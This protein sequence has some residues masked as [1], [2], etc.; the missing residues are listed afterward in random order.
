MFSEYLSMF[1]FSMAPGKLQK[2][3][4]QKK[5]KT[6]DITNHESTSYT[7]RCELFFPQINFGIYETFKKFYPGV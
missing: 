1:G 4:M 6:P 2:F 5:K 3:L 7:P